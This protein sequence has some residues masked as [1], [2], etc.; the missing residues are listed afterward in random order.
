ML[1][2][3]N[4]ETLPFVEAYHADI[5]DNDEE[6]AHLQ[7]DETT[8]AEEDEGELEAPHEAVSASTL[9][10][11]LREVSRKDTVSVPLKE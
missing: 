3:K 9:R 4:Q 10:E 11:E 6:F 8:L 7:Q 1:S 2:A 5:L